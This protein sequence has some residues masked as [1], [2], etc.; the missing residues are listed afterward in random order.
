VGE[1]QLTELLAAWSDGDSTALERLL[2]LVYADL[3]R[4]AARQLRSERADHTL[5]ATAVVH[6]A[7][8]RLVGQRQVRLEDRAAFF[9]A[10][11]TQMRRILV[12]HARRRSAA[13]RGGH[14]MRVT[15]DEEIAA[16]AGRDLDLLALDQA[17][18]ELGAVD[19]RVARIVELRFFGG[20]TVEETAEVVRSSPATVKRDWHSA[21]AWLFREL[22]GP[23]PS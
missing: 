19:P 21:K 15:L 7:Y 11:A 20:L 12:D 10:A 4:I 23:P 6:E 9:A 8:V 2:P 5:S 22:G 1:E 14:E 17:L 13:K 3:R 18:D 16:G